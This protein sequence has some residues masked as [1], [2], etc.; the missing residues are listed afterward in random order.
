MLE[1][2]SDAEAMKYMPYLSGLAGH[3]GRG[4]QTY[5]PSHGSFLA[6]LELVAGAAPRYSLAD[7]GNCNEGGCIKPY[8]KDNMV[9]RLN[10][11]GFTWRGYFQSLPYTGYMGTNRGEYV[12]RHNPFPFI[13]D[14]V[15]NPPQQLNMV[16]WDSNFA[17]DLASGNVANYTWL[18]PDLTHDGHDPGGDPAT[19]LEHADAYLSQQLPLLLQSKYFQPGGDGVLLVTFDESDLDGDDACGEE[20]P[21]GC[22][23]HIFF[24][25]I[26]PNVKRTF[27]TSTHLMQNDMLTGTC[28]LLGV[29]QCPGDGAAGV[30]L[31][32]FFTGA[33][34]GPRVNIFAPADYYPN[35]G[36]WVNVQASGIGNN[37]PIAKWGVYVDGQLYSYADGSTSLQM[38]VPLPMGFHIIGVKAWD[39][40][41]DVTTDTVHV[42]RTW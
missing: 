18:V 31:A 35:S 4:L 3:Y 36:P 2:R 10:R 25:V 32:Q 22:G 40:T 16:P 27:T 37:G 39:G 38:W 33:K 23:G 20:V 1:N 41:G 15:G 13:S 29:T 14:V 7:D 11:K 9:R 24:A 34:I 26:G 8:T 12:R 21:R 19:A 17:D 28:N 30:G 5:S 42:T 6:Y